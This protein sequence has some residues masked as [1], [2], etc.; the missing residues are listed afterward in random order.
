MIFIIMTFRRCRKG[1]TAAWLGLRTGIA[2]KLLA[3]QFV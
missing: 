2:R 1:F 3:L